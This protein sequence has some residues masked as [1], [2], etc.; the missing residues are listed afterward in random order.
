MADVRDGQDV[1]D[2]GCGFAALSISSI[3]ASTMLR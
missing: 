3:A 1:L 2:V